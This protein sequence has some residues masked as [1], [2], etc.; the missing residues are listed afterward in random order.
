M[1]VSS[2]TQAHRTLRIIE[3]LMSGDG[4]FKRTR[5]G[6]EYLKKRLAGTVI[7]INAKKVKGCMHSGTVLSSRKILV[8]MRYSKNTDEANI[9]TIKRKKA[10]HFVYV[11]KLSG[12][13]KHSVYVGMT[14]H[15]PCQRYLNHLRNY[16]AGRHVF[17]EGSP[18]S[19]SDQ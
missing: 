3:E 8:M 19:T 10:S 6:V 12:N 17:R 13:P 14:G 4:N 7:S 15:H 18:Y 11:I 16:K 2:D 1:K 9:P 5:G